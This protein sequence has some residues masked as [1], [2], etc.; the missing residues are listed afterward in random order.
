[1]E[2]TYEKTLMPFIL[3]SKKR[4]VGMLFEN[5]ANTEGKL[6]FMGLSIKR[7]DSCDYLKEVYGKILSILMKDQNVISAITFLNESLKQLIDGN[8]S[9]DKLIITKALRSDYKNPQQ[10][11]HC[12]LANRI[13]ERDPGN[14]P[15][16]GDR[17]KYL[18]IQPSLELS[19]SKKLLMGDKIETPEFIISG[20]A[21]IDYIHYITNQLMNPMT[22]LF[23]L[24]LIQ[25]YQTS[26]LSINKYNNTIEQ[27]K[28]QFGDDIE[29]FN[30]Q[31]D[32]YCAKEIEKLIFEPILIKVKNKINGQSDILKFFK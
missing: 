32:K 25:I 4:Y 15:K 13:G 27:L 21:K 1:M 20:K 26:S 29:N 14:K 18:F 7:R 17:I 12:V 2:L 16:T 9:L 23:S 19:K 11:A 3:L 5:N 30:K 10:I 28:K 8:V 24:A 22:Q 6:K 31:K